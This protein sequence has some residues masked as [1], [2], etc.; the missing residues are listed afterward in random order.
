MTKDVTVAITDKGAIY[1]DDTRI[2][3]R[4]TKWGVH[5]SLDNF[6]CPQHE[7]V[8]QCVERGWGG[9]VRNIDTVPYTDQIHAMKETRG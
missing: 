4:N 1:I 5:N 9:H 7:V 3:N 6:S 2:T 8:A